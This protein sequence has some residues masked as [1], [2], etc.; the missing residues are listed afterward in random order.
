MLFRC[1]PFVL[2]AHNPTSSPVSLFMAT[3]ILSLWRPIMEELA[4]ALPISGAPYTYMY[5]SHL[6]HRLSPTW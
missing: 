6:V 3:L 4:S 2:G 5:V 1:K